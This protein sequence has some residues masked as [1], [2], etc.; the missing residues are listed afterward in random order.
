MPDGFEIYENPNA[1]VFIRKIPPQF[2]TDDEKAIVEDGIC[3][4]A[5]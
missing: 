2:I 5:L 3:R 4:F 1:Q